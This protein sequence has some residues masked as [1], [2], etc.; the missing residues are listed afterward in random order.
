MRVDRGCNASDRS[1]T[2]PSRWKKAG[3]RRPFQFRDVLR[4]VVPPIRADL[5]PTVPRYELP[6][7][8]RLDA[9]TFFESRRSRGG[10]CRGNARI[11]D[12]MRDA[13]NLALPATS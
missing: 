8:V 6:V 4:R 2:A 3:L 13:Y 9:G 10:V 7:N 11:A 5:S 12:A 1:S